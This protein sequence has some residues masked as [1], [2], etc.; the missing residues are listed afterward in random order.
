MKIEFVN[1]LN[2]IGITTEVLINKIKDLYETSC[3]ISPEDFDDI[4]VG[5]FVNKNNMREY[6]GISFF[7]ENYLLSIPNFPAEES[8]VI[9]SLNKKINRVRIT[10]KDFNLDIASETSRMNV[11]AQIS[12]NIW[13]RKAT[14]KNCEYLNKIVGK[15]FILNFAI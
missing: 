6:L 8:F 10:N 13:E 5:D 1:Y 11:Y 2:E 3:K 7:S 12:M 14:G 4:F 15:Y 9:I